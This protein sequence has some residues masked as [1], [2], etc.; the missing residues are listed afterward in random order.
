MLTPSNQLV[1]VAFQLR[2]PCSESLAPPSS[3]TTR[4]L[5]PQYTFNRRVLESSSFLRST[6]FPENLDSSFPLQDRLIIQFPR[7]L[8]DRVYQYTQRVR[9]V[10][11]E[12]LG[13]GELSGLTDPQIQNE[14][15]FFQTTLFGD[16]LVESNHPDELIQLYL[17]QTSHPS[18]QHDEGAIQRAISQRIEQ[19]ARQGNIEITQEEMAL[20]LAANRS[21]RLRNRPGHRFI[22]QLSRLTHQITAAQLS[23]TLNRVSKNISHYIFFMQAFQS[24]PEFKNIPVKKRDQSY[25]QVSSQLPNS[26]YALKLLLHPSESQGIDSANL[27]VALREG[28]RNPDLLAVFLHTFQNHERFQDIPTSDITMGL[29][30]SI[31]SPQRLYTYLSAVTALPSFQCISANPL[32]RILAEASRNLESLQTL[33]PAVQNLSKFPEVSIGHLGLAL[34]RASEN[35]QRLQTLLPVV[36]PLP[37]FRAINNTF[38]GSALVSSSSDLEALQILLPAIQTLPE[39]KKISSWD[40]AQALKGA[41]SNPE[42]QKLLRPA[43]QDHP[44][45]KNIHQDI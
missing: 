3:E 15:D 29:E 9:T 31:N 4:A 5:P 23:H 19:I 20:R 40:L 28:S 8:A 1:S 14:V 39:F 43:I 37:Q 33:L 18:T 11:A 41:E 24:H 42:A 16:L 38:L 27:G 30:S 10:S 26:Q 22:P 35:L 2:P 6:Y 25:T 12:V 7:S 44:Q 36:Q 17:E 21:N 32:G 34:D 13:R 45:F